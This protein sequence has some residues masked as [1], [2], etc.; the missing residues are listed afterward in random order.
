MAPSHVLFRTVGEEGLILNLKTQRD[1]GLDP[2]GTRMWVELTRRE[3]V[4]AALEALLAAYDVEPER[5]RADIEN[6]I[7][8]LA[9]HGLVEVYDDPGTAQV[10]VVTT[11]AKAL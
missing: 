7:A 9:E 11:A 6:W 10:P 4:H 3:S 2:V 5:L 1:L 8:R